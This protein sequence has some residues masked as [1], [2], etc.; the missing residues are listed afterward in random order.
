M[1]YTEDKPFSTKFTPDYKIF[2]LLYICYE[3]KFPLSFF[4]TLYEKYGEMSLFIFKA[5]SCIKSISLTDSKFTKIIEQSKLLYRQI[6]KGITTRH[7][8]KRLSMFVK[9]G[10]KIQEQIPDEPVLD[11]A[12][13]TDEYKTFVTNY[14]QKNIVDMFAD[15]LELLFD[16]G[17]LYDEVKR[18]AIG[19]T[20]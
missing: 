1:R 4:L 6:H 12:L 15:E 14:L 8:I 11:L 3:Y 18:L 5:M 20:A 17:D 16:T 9:N 13:F 2:A 7:Q 10:Y 19:E